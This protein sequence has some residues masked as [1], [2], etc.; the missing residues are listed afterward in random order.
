METFKETS[1]K[2][3][4]LNLLQ[5]GLTDQE[6]IQETDIDIKFINVWREEYKQYRLNKLLLALQFSTQKTEML[7]TGERILINQERSALL[8]NRLNYNLPLAVEKKIAT[9]TKLIEVYQWKPEEN[10]L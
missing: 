5:Q 10:L 6:V 3:H 1:Y 7:K 8:Q 9:I 2:G 4:I